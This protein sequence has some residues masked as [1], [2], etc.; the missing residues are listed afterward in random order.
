MASIL[1]TISDSRGKAYTKHKRCQRLLSSEGRIGTATSGK[2][3]MNRL[4]S[5]WL[6]EKWEM[7]AEDGK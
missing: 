1:E 5:D 2:E 4:E 3:R 7:G 6:E